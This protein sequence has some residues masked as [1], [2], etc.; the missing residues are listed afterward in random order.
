MHCERCL[1][2]HSDALP[3]P[4]AARRHATSRTSPHRPV[5]WTPAPCDVRI[6]HPQG[7][8]AHR[9]EVSKGGLFLGCEEP[10]PPLFTRLSLTLRLG[11][12]DFTCEGEVVRHVDTAHARTW[13][14]TAGIGVQLQPP[15]PRLRELLS[16]PHAPEDAVTSP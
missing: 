16:R 3:C 2:E 13:G 4:P 11:G 15:P 10:F 9:V 7:L 8:Q 12:E 6:Q 5:T 1:S 14:S